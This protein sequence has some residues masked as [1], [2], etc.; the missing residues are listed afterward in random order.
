MVAS[1]ELDGTYIVETARM[2]F[3]LC[4]RIQKEA[5]VRISPS[6]WAGNRDSLSTG[7]L[8]DGSCLRFTGDEK[9]L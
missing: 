7:R 9:A 2:L 5:G 6:T 3:E 8:G 4:V 1:N